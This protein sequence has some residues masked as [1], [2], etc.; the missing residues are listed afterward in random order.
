[1]GPN[2]QARRTRKNM[3]P[4]SAD[5]EEDWQPYPVDPFSSECFHDGYMNTY[6]NTY[7][8]VCICMITQLRI[9]GYFTIS[10]AYRNT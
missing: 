1:M 8:N 5:Q 7:V 6:M 3:F 10:K 2:S 9:R 4:C